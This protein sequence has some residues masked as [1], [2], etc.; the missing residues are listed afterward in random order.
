[1]AWR[2][3]AAFF[4]LA[5]APV[6]AQVDQLAAGRFLVASRELGDP[7]FA[8]AVVLLLQYDAEQGAMGLIVNRRSDLP[9][10]RLFQD[11]KEA[12]GRTDTVYMGGPV[13]LT[14]VLA[15][16]WSRSK[17]EDA[18]RVF[19]DVYLVN[20]KDLLQKTLAAGVEADSF[21]VFVGYAGWGQSQLEHEVELG[22]WHILA[23]DAGN[24]FSSDPD[25]VW[26]RL[27]RRTEMQI[28]YSARRVVSG[29]TWV[30]RRAGR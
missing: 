27:V 20:S 16:L 10:S 19:G 5:L 14:N 30:A 2:F 12:K 23:A 29:S 15:L 21:H 17:P 28:A 9:L 11:M 25:S 8:E 26:Q 24:L 6:V 18:K 7:N 4:V 3:S 1:M 22:A 13:E